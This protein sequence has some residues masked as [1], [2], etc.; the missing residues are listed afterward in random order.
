MEA[1]GSRQRREAPDE[2]GPLPGGHHGLSREQVAE[3]Q[4]ERLLAGIAHVVA[5]RG[6][7]GSTIT[8][9]VKVA[10]VSSR[11]F[12]ENFESKEEC[13]LAAFEAVLAHLEEIVTAAVAPIGDWPHRVVAAIRT[14]LE[15]FAA[16][17]DLARLCLVETLTA[18]PPIAIRFREAVVGATAY[19]EPGRAERADGGAALPDST[20][21]SLI[22]GLVFFGSRSTLAGD[23][24]PELLPDLVDFVLSPYLG[25]EG[26]R[27]LADESA[28]T[29]S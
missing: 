17:P 23:P 22:G 28:A 24:L 21:D 20:E 13:F 3:S 10:S 2:L 18:T 26:A 12:Y 9:I 11:D 29:G 27:R 6:Y 7:R 1:S 4:R 16:E 8:E 19:L 14:A 5:K 25:P 15:F